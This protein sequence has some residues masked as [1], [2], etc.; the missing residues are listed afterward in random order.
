MVAVSMSQPG[1]AGSSGPPDYCGPFTHAA[2]SSVIDYFFTKEFISRDRVAIYG[3]SRGATVATLTAA[4]DKRIK[5]LV[6][7][8]GLYNLL[9]GYGDLKS[10]IK[11]SLEIESGGS[12]IALKERSPY[13]HLEKVDIPTLI[14]HG[15]QD[16]VAHPTWASKTHQRA[17]ELGKDFRLEFFEKYG[18]GIP[19][20]TCAELAG[21]FLTGLGFF[22]LPMVPYRLS[23]KASL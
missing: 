3:L 2:L 14:I 1:Y 9:D 20:S 16:D 17:R 19:F 13:Y 21:E 5:A 4:T 7:T 23:F 8:A 10:G 11:S 22:E 6:L 15:A 12:P 18:H